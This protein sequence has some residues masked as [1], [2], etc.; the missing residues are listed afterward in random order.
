MSAPAS[1][2]VRT[3]S[4]SPSSARLWSVLLVSRTGGP[5]PGNRLLQGEATALCGSIVGRGGLQGRRQRGRPAPFLAALRTRCSHAHPFALPLAPTLPVATSHTCF[6]AALRVLGLSTAGGAL[7][8]LA[9]VV[10]SPTSGHAARPRGALNASACRTHVCTLCL[11][12]PRGVRAVQGPS[13][14]AASAAADL[15]RVQQCLNAG[16]DVN[17]TDAEVCVPGS[18]RSD[19]QGGRQRGYG[20]YHTDK[21]PPHEQPGGVAARV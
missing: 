7:P 4:S 13:L 9:P 1:R 16:E 21:Y 11:T 10:P 20:G 15:R 6:L 17:K 3:Q 19:L 5:L 2:A 18:E 8:T 12:E 14:F